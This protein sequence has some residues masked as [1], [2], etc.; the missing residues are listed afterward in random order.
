[1]K[2]RVLHAIT[3]YNGRP[4]VSRAVESA[5]RM[6]ADAATI[7]VLVLDDC[8]PEPG[9][10]T[11]IEHLCA[12]KGALYYRSPRNLGIPRNVNL[13]LLFGVKNNYDYILI[14]NS[15]VLFPRNLVSVMLEASGS[16]KV[17]SVTAWSNNVSI[18]SLPNTD[19]D[20]F[21]SSQTAVDFMSDKLADK[22]GSAPFDIPAGI[23]FCIMISSELV[24]DIGIMDPIF[25]RGYCEETDWS[26]RSLRAGYRICLAPGT[27]VYHQ[28]RGSNVAAGLVSAHH[29]TVPENEDIIDMRYP[30]FRRQ[31][32]AFE[33]KG[34]MLAKKQQAIRYLIDAA[35]ETNG[36]AIYTGWTRLSAPGTD[37]LTH[38]IIMPD[39]HSLNI[40]FS[41]RGFEEIVPIYTGDLPLQIRSR[42]HGK[43]PVHD[44]FSQN[45][46]LGDFREKISVVGSQR[47]RAYPKEVWH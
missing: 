24:R 32:L 40:S 27:F 17:G 3:V 12:Q 26:L 9:F 19:P 4:F 5:L 34:E 13:G 20:R 35:A 8:S 31:V 30:D 25:G 47:V 21:L 43:P 1:M 15:D 36:Y 11:E 14:N 37:D 45:A 23:S 42:F 10:S 38:V 44:L 2:P 7:D 33:S 29:S 39:Q 41:F 16:P 18:Y 22:F 28:G 46:E 6:D